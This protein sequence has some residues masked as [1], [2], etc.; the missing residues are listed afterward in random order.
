M[1]IQHSSSQWYVLFLWEWQVSC[2]VLRAASLEKQRNNIR[3]L[4]HKREREKSLCAR[5]RSLMWHIT[6]RIEILCV[7]ECIYIYLPL[8]N[9]LTVSLSVNLY[10][11]H[12]K[13]I[14]IWI[15][16]W[17]VSNKFRRWRMRR[18][19]CVAV[20]VMLCRC[21]LLFD[22]ISLC[23]SPLSVYIDMCLVYND[24]FAWL[25]ILILCIWYVLI[26]IVWF[27]IILNRNKPEMRAYLL[28]LALIIA[29]VHAS[30]TVEEG[31]LVLDDENF[32]EAVDTHSMMLV[33]F[34]APW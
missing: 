23:V 6:S 24:D 27:C 33:E 7:S 4:S 2:V 12:N 25:I 22:W 26:N 3:S 11:R 17:K 14:F 30:I 1:I 29:I 18:R 34:Y 28:F 19:S 32:K 8:C 16:L 9:C 13:G 15:T 21:P 10:I 5:D 20:S 31:V